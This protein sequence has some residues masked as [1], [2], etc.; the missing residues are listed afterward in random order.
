MQSTQGEDVEVDGWNSTELILVASGRAYID[1]LDEEY[2]T[3]LA[4]ELGQLAL[5]VCPVED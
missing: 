1:T 3:M 2:D 5:R 4:T